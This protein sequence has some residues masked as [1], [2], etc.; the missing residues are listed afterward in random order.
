[1]TGLRLF[2]LASVFVH[3]FHYDSRAAVLFVPDARPIEGEWLIDDAPHILIHGE[4]RESDL[5]DLKKLFPKLRSVKFDIRPL[6]I[7]DS[8]GGDVLAA[9]SIGLFLRGQKAQVSVA[10]GGSCDSACTFI[11]ASG[12]LRMMRGESRLGIHRPRFEPK[13]FASLSATQAETT[14]QALIERC[15]Q[16]FARMGQDPSLFSDMLR[17]PSGE[18]KFVD[19][20][21]ADKVRLIGSDPA[22]DE[23]LR[24]SWLQRFG[25]EY[26]NQLDRWKSCTESG[27]TSEVCAEQFPFPA[28]STKHLPPPDLGL[29]KE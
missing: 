19:W 27:K 29:P 9:M 12:V 25:A 26:V 21:Y 3:A 28:R 17:V 13:F 18:V 24:A 10:T 16:Y 15:R 8:N 22:F 11:L 1:V 23:W 7:V 5:V 6:V 4:I 2:L 20:D 14:Y